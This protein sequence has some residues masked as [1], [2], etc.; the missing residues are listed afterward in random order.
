MER[1]VS[2]IDRIITFIYFPTPVRLSTLR[3]TARVL[4][5]LLAGGVAAIVPGEES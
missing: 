1:S 5:A 2:L 4:E 3:L